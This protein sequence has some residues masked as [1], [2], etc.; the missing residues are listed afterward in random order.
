[1]RAKDWERI[2]PKSLQNWAKT[3]GADVIDLSVC[4][5]LRFRVNRRNW[6]IV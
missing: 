4:P 5:D 6:N 1:M 2:E 3:G